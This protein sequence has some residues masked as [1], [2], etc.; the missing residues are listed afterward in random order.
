MSRVCNR[1][2]RWWMKAAGDR[3]D[4]ATFYARLS[5]PDLVVSMIGSAGS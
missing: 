1:A 5:E 2:W 3:S 4:E